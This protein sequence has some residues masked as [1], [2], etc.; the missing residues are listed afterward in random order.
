M[1]YIKNCLFFL[2]VLFSMALI[3]ISG[4]IGIVGVYGV[5]MSLIEHCPNVLIG[6]GMIVTSVLCISFGW[7]IFSKCA[8]KVEI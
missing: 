2:G 7:C 6:L 8:T 3:G 4:I 5:F 1:K